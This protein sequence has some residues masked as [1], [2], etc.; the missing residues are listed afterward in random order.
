MALIKL[1]GTIKSFI[2]FGHVGGYATAT[3]LTVE[4][5]NGR[6]HVHSDAL[7]GRSDIM[8]TITEASENGDRIDV[9]I[10]K[11]PAQF[12][13]GPSQIYAVKTTKVAHFD[14]K[15]QF[16]LNIF[17]KWYLSMFLIAPVFI[18][19]HTMF[20]VILAL[21]GLRLY[22]NR[23]DRKTAFYGIDPAVAQQIRN[24]EQIVV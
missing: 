3:S 12:A 4:D 20:V 22:I 8:Q 11:P 5:D 21:F 6:R 17:T 10:E 23:F 16:F 19:P 14:K 1:S 24:M 18:L 7:Y 9:Y 15:K 2:D 13:L